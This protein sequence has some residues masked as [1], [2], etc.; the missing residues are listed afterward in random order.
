MNPFCEIAVEEA[1]RLKEKKI[2]SEIIAVSCGPQQCQETIRT[3][4]AMGADRGIH[5]D[6]PA[7]DAADFGPFQVSKIMA[8]LAKREN[9]NLVLLGKQAID[10][11]CNQTGQMTA[12]L[13]DWPQGTFASEVTVDGEKMT[14]VREIDGGLE[15][16]SLK[17]PAVVT[18]DLRLNEP[19]Y[20]TL[21]NIMKAKKKKIESL[22]PADLGLDLSSRL[23]IVSVEDPPQRQAGVKVE[24]VQDL[25]SKLKESGC[26]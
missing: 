20:A 21:P 15:T 16:I 18:A 23:H 5:V 14:V 12:A 9:V 19:R 22:K 1:V 6:V 4:L 26:I 10:D 11:D 24:T 8:A 13:L 7:K 25:V 17:L 2:V 3:A